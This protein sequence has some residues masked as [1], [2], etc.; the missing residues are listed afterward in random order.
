MLF[1]S[2]VFERLNPITNHF[3]VVGLVSSLLSE[4]E[5]E[6]DLVLIQTS[7]LLLWELSLKNTSQHKNNMIYTRKQEGLYQNKV[8]S[9]LV[10][11]CNCKMGSFLSS[12]SVST[13]VGNGGD[14]KN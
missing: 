8:N 4:W 9:S 12:V 14:G 6:V 11:N 1:P 2:P 13:A 5:A 7:F 10:S 3:K